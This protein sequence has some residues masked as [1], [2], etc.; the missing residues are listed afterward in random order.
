M[1][2]LHRNQSRLECG[3]PD[4][5]I[6]L[7]ADSVGIWASIRCLI[8]CLLTPVVLSLSAVSVHFLPSEERTHRILA[9]AI[10][11][12]G[13]I[14][15]ERI[16]ESSESSRAPIHGSR[17]SLDLRRRLVGRPP[18]F[19]HGRGR[20]YIRWKQLHGC[21]TQTQSRLLSQLPLQWR[22]V[23]VDVDDCHRY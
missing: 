10:A 12:L 4:Q 8:H 16:P 14:S 13:A 17:A 15:L 19:A 9:V 11:M 5:M 20:Y 6:V 21:R 18:A 3:N 22:K 1:N 2:K 7:S 23:T